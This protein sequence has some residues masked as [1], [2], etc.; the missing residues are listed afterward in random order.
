MLVKA[1]RFACACACACTAIVK[2]LVSARE[3]RQC[4][5][6]QVDSISQRQ[7]GLAN[8][9]QN[10]LQYM[11][12]WCPYK[13]RRLSRVFRSPYP[14]PTESTKRP[15][16]VTEKLDADACAEA[17]F[18]ACA[19]LS[20]KACSLG[21]LAPVGPAR[22]SMCALLHSWCSSEEILDENSHGCFCIAIA[23]FMAPTQT[24]PI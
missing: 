18:R 14:D 6:V 24:W 22:L 11:C 16:P 12:A 15:T 5:V 10:R 3:W 13:R 2:V 8:Q 9:D 1:W 4:N 23:V 21:L 17:S 20:M 7:T 19:A